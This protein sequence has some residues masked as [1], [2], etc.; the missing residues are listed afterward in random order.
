MT[1]TVYR[2]AAVLSLF[3]GMALNPQAHAANEPAVAAPTL[4]PVGDSAALPHSREFSLTSSAGKDYRIFISVPPGEPPPEGYGVLLVLDANAYF[5]A[6]ANAM[7]LLR[8]FPMMP[9]KGNWPMP[10]QPWSSA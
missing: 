9:E 10:L 1:N 4:V 3:A 6:A 2:L 7:G 5:G 8:Q